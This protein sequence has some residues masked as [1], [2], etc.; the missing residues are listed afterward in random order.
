[1]VMSQQSKTDQG[2]LAASDDVSDGRLVHPLHVEAFELLFSTATKAEKGK[3]RLFQQVKKTPTTTN[4]F[5]DKPLRKNCLGTIM[6]KLSTKCGLSRSYTN[7]SVRATCITEM[8]CQGASVSTIMGVSNTNASSPYYLT[9][10]HQKLTKLRTVA[11]LDGQ[12]QTPTCGEVV[13]PRPLA[14]ASNFDI[15]RIL[16]GCSLSELAT[17]EQQQA[18]P[19]VFRACNYNGCSIVN[20]ITIVQCK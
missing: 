2:S 11:L 10:A 16:E 14:A 17:L 18:A 7:H 13:E 5:N 6:A 19:V 15:D 9:T 12:V 3:T 4:W 20:N 1:M 8:C